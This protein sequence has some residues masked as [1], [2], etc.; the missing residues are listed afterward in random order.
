M[1]LAT[2]LSEGQKNPEEHKFTQCSENGPTVSIISCGSHGT[3]LWL[4][5]I[6]VVRIA[7][8]LIALTR[9]LCC[10]Q[11]NRRK[12]LLCVGFRIY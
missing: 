7:H 8:G 11:A 12:H 10:L 6:G 9:I 3:I 4:N 5:C 2:G 1:G